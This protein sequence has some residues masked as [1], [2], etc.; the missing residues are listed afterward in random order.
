MAD[1]GIVSLACH[2]KATLLNESE[3]WFLIKPDSEV[4]LPPGTHGLQ[5]GLHD[6]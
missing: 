5:P 3:M 4:P 2:H 6:Q 1:S